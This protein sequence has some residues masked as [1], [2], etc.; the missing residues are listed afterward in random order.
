MSTELDQMSLLDVIAA[1]ETPTRFLH[2]SDAAD[3][4]IAA[5]KNIE[6]TR[7][8]ALVLDAIRNA[9]NLG[10]TAD[11]LLAMFPEHSYSS[12]TARPA[13]LKRKNLIYDSGERRSG[14]SGRSQAVLKAVA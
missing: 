2:R 7:L 4:S 10:V 12:I 6:A 3:T 1:G 13:A 5:A 9:G 8:E 11:E 14:R